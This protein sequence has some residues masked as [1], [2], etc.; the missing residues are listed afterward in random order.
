M[1]QREV[2]DHAEGALLRL[3]ETNEGKGQSR[4]RVES[5]RA[6]MPPPGGRLRSLRQESPRRLLGNSDAEQVLE[7]GGDREEEGIQYRGEGDARRATRV[8]EKDARRTE[9]VAA[10][11]LKERV[12]ARAPRQT[13][14]LV[15]RSQRKV[16]KE[17]A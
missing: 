8:K 12:L 16:P 6:C 13:C 2:Q 1:L 3:K 10:P 17:L 4:R 9:A 14:A 7:S 15:S 5:R 11:S